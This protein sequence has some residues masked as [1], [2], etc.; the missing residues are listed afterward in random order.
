ML[1][2][3]V[4]V[5]LALGLAALSFGPCTQDD[6]F[7]SLRYAANLVEGHGLV[8][9]PGERVEGITN[10]SWTL[11]LAV[12]LALGLDPVIASAAM[13]GVCLLLAVWAARTLGHRTVGGSVWALAPVACI[14]VDPLAVLEAVEGLETALYMAVVTT[15]TARFCWELHADGRRSWRH[16]LPSSAVFAVAATIR[17]EAPLL[18]ALLHGG[19]LLHTLAADR[20]TAAERFVAALAAALPLV[21]TVGALTVFRLSY[22]GEWLPNT[23]YAKS[24][25][26]GFEEGLA[27]LAHHAS[28]H[29]GLWLGLV[30]ATPL[31]V[32]RRQGAAVSAACWGF[33]VY[34]ASVGGDFKP[35]GRFVLP[36]VSLMGAVVA[37]SMAGRSTRLQVGV[38]ACL[39]LATIARLPVVLETAQQWAEVRHANLEARRVVGEFLA[40]NMPPE[41]VLAIHSAGAIPYYAGLPTIDMWGLTD[42]HIARA[43]VPPHHNGLVG[44]MRGDPSYVFENSPDIYLPEEKVFTLRAWPLEVEPDFPDDFERR[45]QS[46]SIPLAGRSLN[47][48]AR[49]GFFRELDER[50]RLEESREGGALD[51]STPE[52]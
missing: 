39:G 38:A 34:V 25:T 49:R 44:H 24:G 45:Y 33:L 3:T 15:G 8:Y 14:A 41:T 46:L 51:R 52:R 13:G 42:K 16:H 32:S 35:T 29:P 17:P 18:P 47:F 10:L 28:G 43:P 9:N 6:T 37:V 31:A 1:L 11:L 5:V 40:E 23:Y 12:P 20:E 50:R 26:A 7:I 4:L 2:V 27:Y 30:L 48:W 21:V 36:V 19:L 22:Y